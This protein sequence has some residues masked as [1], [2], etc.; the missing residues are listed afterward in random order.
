MTF[1]S[2]TTRI[3]GGFFNYP[4]TRFRNHPTLGSH[5]RVAGHASEGGIRPM[6]F[7]VSLASAAAAVSF[8][9]PSHQE[10]RSGKVGQKPSYRQSLPCSPPKA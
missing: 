8:K 7:G 3:M 1:V 5:R 9:S 6:T 2:R 10:S 4:V